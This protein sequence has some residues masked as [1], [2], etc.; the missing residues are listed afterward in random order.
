M[1]VMM[2]VAKTHHISLYL[3]L[4][5]SRELDAYRMALDILKQGMDVDTY[6]KVRDV[7]CV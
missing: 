5:R 1:M 7:S 6:K 3:S 2:M 4:N